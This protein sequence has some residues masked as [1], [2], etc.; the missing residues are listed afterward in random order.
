MSNYESIE[1]KLEGFIKKFYSNELI[2]GM[3]LFVSIGLLYFIVTLFIEYFLWLR[4][5]ARTVLFWLFIAVEV[6]LFSKYV[7]FPILKLLGFQKGISKEDASRIIGNHFPEVSDKLLNILQLKSE[8]ES[9]LVLAS[10]DQ[11]AK[12]LRPIPFKLAIDFSNNKKYLKY[13]A[14][15]VIIYLITLFSGNNDVFSSS[16]ERVINYNTAYEPPAPFEFFVLNNDLS[17]ERNKDFIIRVKTNGEIIPD[18]VNIVYNNETYIL[19]QIGTASFEYTVPNVSEEL[20]FYLEG[21]DVRSRD[22]KLRVVSVPVIGSFEMELEYPSYLG[23]NNTV[24]KNT[25]NVIIPEG[26]NVIWMLKTISTSKVE[27]IGDEN[28]SFKKNNDSEFSYSKRIV[29]DLDYKIATSNENISNYEELQYRISVIKDQYPELTIEKRTDTINNQFEHFLGKASD[30]YG[31]H[32]L[33]LVYFENG[34]DNKQSKSIEI[35]KGTFGQFI[36]TFPQGLD[37]KEGTAYEYYFEVFDN[38]VRNGF[39]STKSEVFSYRK[40]TK[41]EEESQQLQQQNDA[42]KGLNNSLE[43]L[44]KQEKELLEIANKQKENKELKWN[45]KKKLDNFIKKQRQQ[46]E[47]MKNFNEKLE[48]NLNEFQKDAESDEFKEAI[49][50]RLNNQKKELNEN[51]KLLEELKELQDKIREEELAKKIE[52]L[53]KQ[54]QEQQRSLEQ[55]VELT[56]RYYV[57]KK[58]EKLAKELDKLADDQKELSEKNGDENTKEKQD[59]LNDRF[60]KLQKEMDDLQKE[61]SDLKKPMDLNQDKSGEKEVQ[62]QQ[63]EASGNLDSNKQKKAKQNQKKAADKMK[64]MSESMM[65]MM[66]MQSG[67]QLEADAKTL[68]QILDNLVFY[69]FEQEELMD[70]F[71]QID[72]KNASYPKKL[73]RQQVLREHFK[74]VDDSLFALS[75][76]NPMISDKVNKEITDVHFNVDK[77]I[78]LF[79]ETDVYK[80]TGNQQYAI[81]AANN[82]ADYLSEVLNNMQNQM[83]NS[84]PGG[85]QCDKPGGSGQGFQLSDIIQ[86]QEQNID[87]MKEGMENKGGK[88]RNGKDGDSKSGEKGS[89]QQGGSGGDE[90]S[91]GELFR[92]Y[93]E[94]QRLREQLKK[95]L[96]NQNGKGNGDLLKE[97]EEIEEQLLDKGF[98]NEVLRK[99]Q[100]LKHELLKL[101][102]ARLKQG[103][104][105]KREANTNSKEFTNTNNVAVPSAKDYFNEVE[106]LNRQALPLQSIY[107]EKVNTYFKKVDD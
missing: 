28:V 11:K 5:M 93:Q 65:Q 94:Q 85:G 75:L 6:V 73:K 97:M 105:E 23:K 38:D 2:K 103:Q 22:Y 69:S 16:Y 70:N 41:S 76:R 66:M 92:I 58:A 61:N 98:T 25:G 55:L 102:D 30:D 60:D 37:L 36:Y 67:E 29:N 106:I 48:R 68:R 80:G 79:A 12:D 100:D 9:E 20:S 96:G 14:V 62:E 18:N 10:I 84:M 35:G 83:Q 52:N 47:L 51:E 21:N 33:R 50:E 81:T 54:N 90:D 99:M 91:S 1:D 13:L 59:E 45:D 53:Q 26:T 44:E 43:K 87:K 95:A 46:D 78:E 56:K 82:L 88:D 15:P 3:L 77:A 74:H 107:K 32:K 89:Q 72:A 19:K 31:I 71:K 39:K 49:K 34:S 64:K 40:L 27:F 4:P 101:E 17:V 63:K 86:Q 24:I 7:I 57:S 42:I 104:E 8:N